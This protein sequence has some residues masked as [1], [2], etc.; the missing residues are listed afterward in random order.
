MIFLFLECH[1]VGI[2]IMCS[3][4]PTHLFVRVPE[5]HFVSWQFLFIAELHYIVFCLFIQLSIEKQFRCF[6]FFTIL[7]KAHINI[8]VQ[9]L[10]R[11]HFCLIWMRY[12]NKILWTG[13]FNQQTI[14]E[15]G[16]S[17]IK[18]PTISFLGDNSFPSLESLSCF[19][20]T[21][22][23]YGEWELWCLYLIKWVSYCGARSNDSSLK[24]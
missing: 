5:N 7:T 19:L 18:M 11:H 24:A 22:L 3:S 13:R 20:V 4:V 17:K 12:Y 1:R 8:C 6:Q 2:Y 10:C 21:L 23:T 9:N 15:A 14:L 16:R